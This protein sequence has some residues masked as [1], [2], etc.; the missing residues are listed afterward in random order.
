MAKINKEEIISTA[1]RNFNEKVTQ[2][3]TQYGNGTTNYA[4]GMGYLSS[5]LE[6]ALMDM[7]L[8]KK[9]LDRLK[10]SLGV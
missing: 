8:T 9:Q 2:R 7:N 4:Y 1:L 10:L 6:L 3:S 5:S